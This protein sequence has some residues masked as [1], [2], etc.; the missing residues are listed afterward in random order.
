MSRPNTAMGRNRGFHLIFIS[1][2]RTSL[3]IHK[4]NK[5]AE[6]ASIRKIDQGS[7]APKASGPNKSRP[8]TPYSRTVPACSARLMRGFA[9]PVALMRLNLPF[10]RL[11]TL[12]YEAEIVDPELTTDRTS[13]R[14]APDVQYQQSA[15]VWGGELSGG[16]F[17]ESRLFQFIAVIQHG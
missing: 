6:P 7:T 4:R 17:P 14:Q 1:P 8:K 16:R 2:S 15:I 12:G 9:V 5:A 10:E 13:F 11:L 3:P